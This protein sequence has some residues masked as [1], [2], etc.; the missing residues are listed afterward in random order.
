[1][2]IGKQ[3]C[4]TL[5]NVRL[6]VARANDIPY[7]PV[8]CN[9][10]GDCLGT[11]PKCEEELHYINEQLN[12][13]RSLGKAVT[14][15]GVSLG[16]MPLS[17]CTH[18]FGLGQVN[19][20]LEPPPEQTRGEV[21]DTVSPQQLKETTDSTGQKRTQS[22]VVQ[23]DTCD[24]V[25]T[26]GILPEVP[27]AFPGGPSALQEFLDA[28]INYPPEDVVGRVV[29]SFDVETDGRLTNV[30]IVKHLSEGSDKEA[31]RLISIMPKWKPGKF[32]GETKVMS[33][34]MPVIFKLE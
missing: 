8:E 16:L 18:I 15:V 30:K 3:I 2:Y 28:N 29:V 21:P 20:M 31:L 32:N 23:G 13:R 7:K 14:V 1:M 34:T 24:H 17:S 10:K 11:C 12:L 19:G 26:L 4:K 27:P 9:H 6:Q 25:V 22:M 5:K 33:Y